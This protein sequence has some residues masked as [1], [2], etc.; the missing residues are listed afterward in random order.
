MKYYLGLIII[1]AFYRGY[2]Q[3]PIKDMIYDDSIKTVSLYRTGWETGYPFIGL[4]SSA[5]LTC[6]FDRLGTEYPSYQYTIIHC[7]RNWQPSALIKSDYVDIL[8]DI[9]IID[10]EPSGNTQVDY[11]HYS[12]SFPNE[13]LDIKISG[14][15]IVKVFENYDQ[16]KPVIEKRF[17]VV[18]N[19]VT[20]SMNAQ[21]T[22]IVQYMDEYQEVDFTITL[23]DAVNIYNPYEDIYVVLQQNGRWDNALKGLKPLYVKSDEL[24]YELEN[25]N[26]F[27]GSNEFRQINFKN[28][29]FQTE[30]IDRY[31]YERGTWNVF[32]KPDEVK[33][34]KIYMQEDDNN[35]K[36]LIAVDSDLDEDVDAEYA[37]VHFTLPYDVMEIDGDI[38]V[39]GGISNWEISESNRMEFNS[40]KMQ[41][42]LTMLLKQGYYDYQYVYVERGKNEIDNTWIEGSHYQT[43]NDYSLFIY[44]R[45]NSQD[46]DRIIGYKRVNTE[47]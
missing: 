13:D 40:D 18:E 46:Y 26:L 34:F 37:Y 45:D 27:A 4:S 33:R 17:T 24:I 42:E 12:F 16:T 35:G 38:Y 14:N 5:T 25:E 2:S 29:N 36:F 20:I 7:D 3:E 43:E 41:Y 23:S 47:N 10:V 6:S 32:V 8:G 1:L 11:V 28:F 39:F 9:E 19:L 22:S 30:F 15:Y 44:T 31:M 21:R